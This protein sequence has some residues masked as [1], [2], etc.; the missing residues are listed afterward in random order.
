MQKKS[1]SIFSKN[2]INNTIMARRIAMVTYLQVQLKNVSL[3]VCS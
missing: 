2:T 3:M 1:K